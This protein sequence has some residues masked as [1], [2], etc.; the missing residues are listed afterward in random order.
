MSPTFLVTLKIDKFDPGN[1]NDNVR[2]GSSDGTMW[3]EDIDELIKSWAWKE[4]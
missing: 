2:R 3:F 4:S 1:N